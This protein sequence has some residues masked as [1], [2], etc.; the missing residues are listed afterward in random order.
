MANGELWRRA[1]VLSLVLL[2]GVSFLVSACSSRG[3]DGQE[4]RETSSTTNAAQVHDMESEQKLDSRSSS[5]VEIRAAT[6]LV[7]DGEEGPVLH[8]EIADSPEEIR[9]GLMHRK[10]M[11][12]DTGM[13]FIMPQVKP[14]S[15][16]MKNTYIPLSI[17]FIRED[18]E[19][20][21]ILEMKPLDTSLRYRSGKACKY[22]LEVPQGWF[23]KHGIE[24]GDSIVFLGETQ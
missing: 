3:E 13:L 2:T 7:D 10:K 9:R 4:K 22:A 12:K 15:F 19:I 6:F 20:V 11:Q 18:L 21:R 14:L 8:L 17:A 24:A 5:D 23:S 1:A 16:W